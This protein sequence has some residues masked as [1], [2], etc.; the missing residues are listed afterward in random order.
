V[1]T[2]P[3]CDEKSP[4]FSHLR[5]HTINLSYFLSYSFPMIRR[6]RKRHIPR[7]TLTN[8]TLFT[9]YASLHTHP[10]Q[11]IFNIHRTDKIQC[12][13]KRAT[14]ILTFVQEREEASQS[15]AFGSPNVPTSELSPQRY[16]ALSYSNIILQFS[17][18]PA[19]TVGARASEVVK[20]LSYKPEDRGFETR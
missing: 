2:C 5:L 18:V 16:I 14:E 10:H 6:G 8:A 11:N 17:N 1:Y 13:G 4:S 20:A 12:S 3:E 19:I 15:V 7:I 9:W